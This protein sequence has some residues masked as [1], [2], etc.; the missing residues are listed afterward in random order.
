MTHLPD[1]YIAADHHGFEL[2]NILRDW[3]NK[4]GYTVTDFGP[5]KA[6]PDDDYPDYGIKVAEAVAQNPEK[7]L[8][9]VICSSGVGMA[10]AADKVKGVR[11]GL[12]H[13]PLLAKAAREDDDI[14]VLALGAD[15]ISTDEAKEVVKVWLETPFSGA[16]RHTRRLEKI[17]AYERKHA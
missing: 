17:S 15:Y 14:N 5:E 9:I 4:E 11:A 10:V 1:V 2:K 12:I 3:L 7:R 6:T 8:G 13:H 16:E